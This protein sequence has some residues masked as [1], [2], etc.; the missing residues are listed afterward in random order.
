MRDEFNPDEI[1]GAPLLGVNGVV[2]IAHGR[3]NPYAIQ[4]AIGQARR[5][6]EG[7]IVAAIAEGLK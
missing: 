1:G 4:Q 7:G 3:S 5:V 2:I 6:A